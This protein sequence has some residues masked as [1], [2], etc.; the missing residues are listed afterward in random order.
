MQGQTQ[1]AML[2][3]KEANEGLFAGYKGGEEMPL[4]GYATLVG[5]YNAYN[6]VKE[7]R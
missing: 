3:S 5:V 2:Q 7:K 6:G 1:G 4:A